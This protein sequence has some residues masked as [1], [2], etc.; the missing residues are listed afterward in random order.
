[1]KI[2]FQYYN[3]THMKS[4]LLLIV[5]FIA[6]NTLQA[7]IIFN[8]PSFEDPGCTGTANSAAPGWT[9]CALSPDVQPGIFG[10]TTPPQNGCTYASFCDGEFLCTLLNNILLS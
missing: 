3:K 1:M 9:V 8:N 5:A 10:V 4:L 2:V 7:Q 6:S